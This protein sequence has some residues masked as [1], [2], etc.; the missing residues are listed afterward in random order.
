MLAD[1]AFRARLRK[2]GLTIAREFS[3]DK[4]GRKALDLLSE[5]RRFARQSQQCA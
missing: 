1:E 4:T 2:H 5:G 3:W